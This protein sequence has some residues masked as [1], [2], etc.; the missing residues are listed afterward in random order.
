M[1]IYNTSIKKSM[2]LLFVYLFKSIYIIFA[3]FHI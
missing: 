2:P 1:V 3:F